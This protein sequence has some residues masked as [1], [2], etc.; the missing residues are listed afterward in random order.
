M[1]L[2]P[3]HV[4]NCA[5]IDS[6]I[7]LTNNSGSEVCAYLSTHYYLPRDSGLVLNERECRSNKAGKFLKMNIK[8]YVTHDILS[9][10]SKQY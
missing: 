2:K 9:L 5:K 6:I 7:G 8:N 3:I 10:F 4:F 1:R